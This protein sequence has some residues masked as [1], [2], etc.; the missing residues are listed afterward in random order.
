[1]E[2]YKLQVKVN[3]HPVD[4]DSIDWSRSDIRR[5]Q[6]VQPPG[7]ANVLGVVKF[8]F[9]NK[10]D[11]YMHD[12]PERNLFG[13]APRAFSHGC[14]RTQNPI[15]LAE[16]LLA[17][18]KGYSAA[19]VHELL[20]EGVT[21]EIRLSSEIPVHIVYFTAEV[22]D[23]GKVRYLPDIY[24][25]DSRIASALKGQ[26]VRLP[27]EAVATADNAARPRGREDDRDYYRNYN[28][29]GYGNPYGPYR[30]PYRPYASGPRRDWNFFDWN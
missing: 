9:P 24:G 5:Y 15:H 3:G 12:T 22:D 19:R 6:F 13:A 25:L 21:N 26:P 14:M 2:G 29:R 1:M 23:D 11:V 20:D 17:H 30:D 18:D 27:S 7:P 8:R 28:D 16:V 10:H 4:P